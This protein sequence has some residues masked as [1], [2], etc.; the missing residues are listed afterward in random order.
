[1][2]NERITE[3]EVD[4][5]QQQTD[6]PDTTY[7]GWVSVI[8]L[9]LGAAVVRGMLAFRIPFP[10]IM[11]DELRFWEYAHEAAHGVFSWH[12][13]GVYTGYPQILYPL[14]L[15]PDLHWIHGIAAQYWSV[16]IIGAVVMSSVIFPVYAWTRELTG[17]ARLGLVAG[18]F[19]VSVAGMGYSANIMAEVLYYPAF[20]W[21]AYLLWKVLARDIRWPGVLL[22]GFIVGLL[23]FVKPQG[24]IFTLLTMLCLIIEVTAV[25]IGH[26][27]GHW[28]KVGSL[29]VVLLV[30]LT[31]LSLRFL[32]SIQI[33]HMSAELSLRELFFGGYAKQAPGFYMPDVLLE[34]RTFL[35]YLA[36][37]GLIVG[38]IPFYAA[39]TLVKKLK[40]ASYDWFWFLTLMAASVFIVCAVFARNTVVYNVLQYHH[41]NGTTNLRFQERYLF[42]LAPMF[43][44]AFAA[45]LPNL[46]KLSRW[47]IILMTFL[48]GAAWIS[49]FPRYF[50][51]SL[52]VDSP[53]LTMPFYIFQQHAW[54]LGGVLL[55]LILVVLFA[56][57]RRYVAV[58][59]VFSFLG[60][61]S[62]GWYYSVPKLLWSQASY[63]QIAALTSV[64]VPR[65]TPLYMVGPDVT[66][67]FGVAFWRSGP[68][69]I[70]G[71]LHDVRGVALLPV[72]PRV[73]SGVRILAEYDGM[74][75]VSTPVSK[76]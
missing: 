48:F 3:M 54:V 11:S 29:L 50:H 71:S 37:L 17:S 51:W 45:V 64:Y 74:M 8:A 63:K 38:V 6:R 2:L 57:P 43:G 67:W 75:L 26:R 69:R 55:A 52:V 41:L 44:I 73:P 20:V 9:W 31:V 59:L 21:A 27:L 68:W 65:S 33:Q 34:V 35:D 76:P 10:F 23:Y 15:A 30:A 13:A 24:L 42:P 25:V 61:S 18:V 5:V 39:W 56:V 53:S 7:S 16:K 60:I 14:L 1:M 49:E 40:T 12:M 36:G 72:S 19:A 62:L 4:A 32:W 28:P 46:V 47:L 58:A 70:V 66:V 22:A